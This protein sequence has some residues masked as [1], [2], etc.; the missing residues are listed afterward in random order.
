[1]DELLARMS[2]EMNGKSTKR[3][4]NEVKPNY[5]LTPEQQNKFLTWIH[6]GIEPERRM[7]EFGAAEKLGCRASCGVRAVVKIQ[8]FLPGDVAEG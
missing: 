2:S 3:K 8:N 1:M 5:S 6:N 4:H 7:I